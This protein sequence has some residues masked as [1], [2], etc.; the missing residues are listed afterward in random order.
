MDTGS[1]VNGTI[2]GVRCEVMNRT[3]KELTCRTGASTIP[4][5][6]G[7][8][9]IFFD[10]EKEEFVKHQFQYKNDPQITSARPE[11]STTSGGLKVEIRG[12]NFQ[13]LQRVRMFVVNA[14]QKYFSS[15]LC[16]RISS[17]KFH[18]LTPDLKIPNDPRL[19]PSFSR[20]WE[21]EY[22][23]EVDGNL[24]QL[25]SKPGFAKQKVF[26]DPIL[27]SFPDNKIRYYKGDDYLTINGQFLNAAA[28]D[29]DVSIQIGQGF[30]NLTALAAPALTCKPPPV[31]PDPLSSES[32]HPEV[33]V[34]IGNRKYSVGY[35]SYEKEKGEISGKHRYNRLC[36]ERNNITLQCV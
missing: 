35:L 3:Q 15:E 26:P 33:I 31:K 14:G 6:T 21:L 5:K 13:L 25:S 29:D 9:V 16:Q 11:V 34:K 30:C 17:E 2:A 32:Q 27:E 4:V 36:F 23:L 24:K 20:P 10:N 8:I 18:C 28:S 7:A 1:T 12:D 22:G 19:Q